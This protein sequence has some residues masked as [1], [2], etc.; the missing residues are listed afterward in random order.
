[1]VNKKITTGGTSKYKQLQIFTKH[2]L[3]YTTT[4]HMYLANYKF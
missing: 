4:H 2:Q 1:M 3:K